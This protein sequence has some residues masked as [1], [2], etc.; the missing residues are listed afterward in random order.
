M[1]DP[2][3]LLKAA[4][5]AWQSEQNTF[6]AQQLLLNEVKEG[7]S[8]CG[9]EDASVSLNHVIQRSEES[10]RIRP[11]SSRRVVARAQGEMPR[12]RSA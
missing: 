1:S 12:V 9:G 8:Q 7:I 4:R 3:E 10:T 5:Y 2:G 6:R 11:C